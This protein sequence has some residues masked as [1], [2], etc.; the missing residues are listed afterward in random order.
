M[1][2]FPRFA[3]PQTTI[4]V[5][6]PIRGDFAT[7]NTRSQCRWCGDKRPWKTVESSTTHQNSAYLWVVLSLREAMWSPTSSS[8]TRFD[9]FAQVVVSF[10]IY[11]LGFMEEILFAPDSPSWF[12]D[13]W[14]GPQAWTQIQPLTRC[15]PM[16]RP[17][18]CALKRRKVRPGKG[19][20]IDMVMAWNSG[21]GMA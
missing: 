15:Q 18:Y 14:L 17:L 8:L 12:P 9:K 16:W 10:C 7:C 5:G 11:L 19:L 1:E 2:V 6:L 13:F 4:L 21:N 3:D 20:Q